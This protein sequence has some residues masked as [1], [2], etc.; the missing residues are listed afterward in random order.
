VQQRIM[1]Y[2]KDRNVIIG[3]CA[4]LTVPKDIHRQQGRS[5]CLARRLCKRG[6]PFGAYFSSNASTL[7]WAAKTG[8]LTIRPDAV[9]HSIIYDEKA[10]RAVGV[11]VIDRLTNAATEYFAHVIFVNASTLN[12]NQILL[13]STSSRFPQGLGNDNG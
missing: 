6:C 4:H 12:S 9:V 8:N 1:S 11:R 2:Y 3:R 13:N 5:Q 10:G 7:P